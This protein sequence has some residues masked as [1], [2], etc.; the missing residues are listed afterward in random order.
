[1]LRFRN[2]S[3]RR[4]PIA[5]G[6]VVLALL[7]TAATVSTREAAAQH[8]ANDPRPWLGV[9]MALDAG[10]SGVIVRHVVRNSPA[11]RAG[12]HDGDRIATVDGRRVTTA[13]EVTTFVAAHAVGDSLA[14]VVS[15]REHDVE[16]HVALG[17]FPQGDEMI[18]MDHVGTFAPAWR[19]VQQ[20]SGTVPRSISDLRGRVVLIDFW[21]TWCGP[22][23]FMSPTLNALQA[24][25]GAQGLSVIGISSE[26]AEE[27]SLFAQ[28]TGMAYAVASDAN[29]DT[30]QAY[31][32]SSLPTLFLIDKRGVVRDIEIGYDSGRDAA[33]ENLV[34]T[35]LNEP[36]PSD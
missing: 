1:M 22:C 25:Y 14:V 10:G 28:R 3:R 31:T 19:G 7:T 20:V 5:L 23:R 24:R 11:D 2:M 15:R 35:L 34:K 6:S 26:P 16:L 21:A 27:V 33:I 4:V 8:R 12:V 30:T 13:R 18:R 17:A 9:A 29:G 36:A 32:V